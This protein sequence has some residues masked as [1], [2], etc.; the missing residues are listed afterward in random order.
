MKRFHYVLF[1]VLMSGL[2]GSLNLYAANE[3]NDYALF[4]K[5]FTD[6]TLA[7][8]QKKLAQTCAL[9]SKDLKADF[10]GA[11][12]KSYDSICEGFKKVFRQKEKRYHYRFKINQVYRSGNLAAVRITWY[13]LEYKKGRLIS[14]TQDEGLDV[15]LKDSNHQWKI[16]NYIA[17][18]VV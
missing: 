3:S 4:E 18:P 12:I 6:W 1:L 7:F 11:P 5:L 14:K 10:Q 8:N 2:L 15:F 9:F 16:V 13:F 17:Y